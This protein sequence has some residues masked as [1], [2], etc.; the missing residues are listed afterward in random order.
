MKLN[1]PLDIRIPSLY[2]IITNS[3]ESAPMPKTYKIINNR[4]GLLSPI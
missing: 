2:N 3:K 4:K 1:R